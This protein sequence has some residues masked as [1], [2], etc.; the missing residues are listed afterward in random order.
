[1]QIDDKIR[2]TMLPAKGGD[3][4][5]IE[6][7]RENYYILID[8]GYAD[9][10]YDFL[11]DM[12]LDLS[13]KGKRIQLLVITHIDA[14]HIGG[15][16]AFL[17][18]NGEADNPAIIGVDEVWYNAFSQISTEPKQQGFASGYLRMV[19]QGKALQGNLNSKSGSHD[20][21]VTQG[22]T[23]AELLLKHRYR[24]N[25]RFMD[26]TV[27]TENVETV[28][29][30]DKIRCNLL[31]PGKEELNQLVNYWISDMKRN[32]RNFKIYDDVLYNAAFEGSLVNVSTEEH[33]R[34]IKNIS[35][36]GNQSLDHWQTKIREWAAKADHS[37]T[38]RSSISF[39]LQYD[40]ITLL[41]SGD[42][43]MQLF[44]K[45]LPEH[46][47]VVKLPHHGS[48]ANISREFIKKTSVSYY[49]LSTDG[50]KYGHPSH[51]VIGS[52]MDEAP[53]P[54]KIIKNY[55]ISQLETIGETEGETLWKS[56][57][58]D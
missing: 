21:S 6:F 52:I 3:C 43:P 58:K 24:W 37:V 46:I 18:E 49:L 17:R 11:K 33:E 54:A 47:D 51:C 13:A 20:I 40:D 44:Q 53:I 38:N 19:L 23:V 25:E 22:N 41:F 35:S 14:D 50:E 29:L 9:T 10:Y 39:L 12:L 28:M 1:M 8:G 45:K 36:S 31:N 27:Y 5:L 15:I 4:I 26:R 16:Q 34:E 30:S 55:D 7:L 48:W 2:I 56:K 32:I 57:T 42:C